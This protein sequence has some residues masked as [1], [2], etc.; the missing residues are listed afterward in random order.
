MKI[1]TKTGDEGETSLHS[2]ER[3]SKESKIV[4]AYGTVD[5]LNSCLGFCRQ[6]LEGELLDDV[7]LSIQRDLHQLASDVA[8]SLESGRSVSRLSADQVHR[9]EQW[10]DENEEHLEPLRNF[11]VP[12]GSDASSRLHLARCVCRRAERRLLSLHKTEKVNPEV[13][14]Y[15]N[16]LSDLLFVLARRANQLN[17]VEDIAWKAS[18]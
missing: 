16:R 12:G 15:L 3:V 8:T 6:A 4:E 10:I 13:L 11:I 14:K 7:V 2:G 5:E 17:G 18:T 9:L 1:Y